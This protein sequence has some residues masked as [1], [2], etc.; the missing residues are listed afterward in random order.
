MLKGLGYSDQ[1]TCRRDSI[2]VVAKVFKF[3]GQLKPQYYVSNLRDNAPNFERLIDSEELLVI[4]VI[5]ELC[6]DRVR[7]ECDGVQLNHPPVGGTVFQR[8]HSRKRR[9]Q[10]GLVGQVANELGKGR[11]KRALRL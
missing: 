3:F 4:C 6:R 11:S 10:D 1:R 5:I 8:L 2:Q 7:N 9:F